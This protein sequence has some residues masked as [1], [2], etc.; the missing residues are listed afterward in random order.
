V[1]LDIYNKMRLK[2]E[3]ES[4]DGPAS[5][6]AQDDKLKTKK[7]KKEERDGRDLRG[8]NCIMVINAKGVTSIT[9]SGGQLGQHRPD[10]SVCGRRK[11][12]VR[13]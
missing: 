12:G 1:A 9:N 8:W 13:Q 4:G 2:R 6:H 3:V 5:V 7:K 10:L 11:Y